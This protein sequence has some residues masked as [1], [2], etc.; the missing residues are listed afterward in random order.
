LTSFAIDASH[1]IL[2]STPPIDGGRLE[3]SITRCRPARAGTSSQKD[4][5]LTILTSI[6]ARVFSYRRDVN[7]NRIAHFAILNGDTLR[8]LHVSAR[9]SQVGYGEGDLQAVNRFL[10]TFE[11]GEWKRASLLNQPSGEVLAKYE[12]PSA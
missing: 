11:G 6:Y 5:T 3:S 7:G 12:R 4:L 1:S 9:R 2:P 10:K 8:E